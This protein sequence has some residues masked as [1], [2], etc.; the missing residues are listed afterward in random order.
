MELVILL[1]TTANVRENGKDIFNRLHIHVNGVPEDIYIYAAAIATERLLS[2]NRKI[3]DSF[4][5]HVT[6]WVEK[7]LDFEEL[8]KDIQKFIKSYLDKA[9]EGPT[10]Y[11]HPIKRQQ[12]LKRSGFP[13]LGRYNSSN[14]ILSRMMESLPKSFNKPFED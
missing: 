6:S 11:E 2:W 8:D 13:R 3:T 1:M 4:S 7:S 12:R 9:W 14:Q 5:V 10:I